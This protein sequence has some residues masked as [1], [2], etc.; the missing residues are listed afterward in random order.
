[1][2]KKN[3]I[4]VLGTTLIILL[5]GFMPIVSSSVEPENV[6]YKENTLSGESHV[7]DEQFL[8]EDPAVL[9]EELIAN[10]QSFHDLL[11]ENANDMLDPE[12]LIELQNNIDI[13][14]EQVDVMEINVVCTVL[15]AT[16]AAVAVIGEIICWILILKPFL[17]LALTALA[18][19]IFIIGLAIGNV[20]GC[21]WAT[22]LTLNGV[23]LEGYE[24]TFECQ[25]CMI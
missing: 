22:S 6:T 9:L 23:T 12:L 25:A 4:C 8:N 7:L 18:T 16:L 24:Q 19:P 11:E 14:S 13:L 15:L 21:R 5:L 17:R 3:K 20:L 10:L 1:M 2:N